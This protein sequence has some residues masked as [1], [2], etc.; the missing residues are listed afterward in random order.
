[1]QTETQA[2]SIVCGM[3][4]IIISVYHRVDSKYHAHAI[5]LKM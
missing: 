4:L 5:S 1:M 2:C 3:L